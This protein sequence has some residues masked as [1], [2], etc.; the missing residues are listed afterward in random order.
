ML[1]PDFLFPRFF[2][3][4]RANPSNFH[5]ACFRINA[6]FLQLHCTYINLYS[7]MKN[8]RSEKCAETSLRQV[9]Y[10]E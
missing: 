3:F 6:L 5:T 7:C 1:S 10:F 2:V 4:P 8:Y 9:L